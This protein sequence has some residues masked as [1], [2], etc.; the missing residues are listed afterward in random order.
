MGS[1]MCI[2]DRH[3]AI[4]LN[5]IAVAWNQKAFEWGRALAHKPTLVEELLAR[6]TSAVKF[7]DVNRAQPLSALLA[8]ELIAYQDQAYAQ[9]FTQ[10][11]SKIDQHID[12]TIGLN[13]EL[14]DVIARSLFKLMAYKDE[15][16]VA[17]L[18]S[19]PKFLKTLAQQFDGDYRLV[20]NL[21]PPLLSLSLIHISEPTRPY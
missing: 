17:R 9:R 21:A 19:S 13:Q 10:W 5:G 12:Q 16:E 4:E 6:D 15:Y 1:E 18:H 8:E 3:N 14:S 2:R 20:F 11:L 7:V